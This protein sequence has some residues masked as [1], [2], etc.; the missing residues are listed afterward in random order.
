MSLVVKHLGTVGI[1]KWWNVVIFLNVDLIL[2]FLYLQGA[3]VHFF[4]YTLN[5]K[6]VHFSFCKLQ[7][8]RNW[9]FAC[10]CCLRLFRTHQRKLLKS[11]QTIPLLH[12]IVAVAVLWIKIFLYFSILVEANFG[13]ERNELELK[14]V[15]YILGELWAA[16]AIWN[17]KSVSLGSSVSTWSGVVFYGSRKFCISVF[18]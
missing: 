6:L 9:S 5:S 14:P 18:S 17:L 7:S 13:Q 10:S 8:S 3:A 2:L 11:S 4:T 12:L 16:A 1:K 15:S